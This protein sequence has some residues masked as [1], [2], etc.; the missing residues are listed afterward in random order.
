MNKTVIRILAL[1]LIVAMIV[2]MFFGCGAPADEPTTEPA[3]S[4]NMGANQEIPWTDP[5]GWGFKTANVVEWTFTPVG[6]SGGNVY[7]DAVKNIVESG[8]DIR[9]WD[10]GDGV[11]QTVYKPIMASQYLELINDLKARGY[12]VYSQGDLNKD[13]YYTLLTY[14]DFVYS[15]TYYGYNAEVYVTASAQRPLSPYLLQDNASTRSEAIE[16]L[17]TKLTMLQWQEG[18][19]DNYIIQLKSGHFIV[20]DGGSHHMLATMLDFMEDNVPEGQVPVV[21]AWFVTHGHYDHTGWSRAFYEG[22]TET[23]GLFRTGEASQRVRVNGVYLNQTNQQVIEHTIY[24][25]RSD[26]YRNKLENKWPYS[27]PKAVEYMLTEDG[28]KTPLYRPQAGQTLYFKDLTVE[29]PYTQEQ[30]TFDNY[31]MDINAASTWHLVRAEGRTFLDAGDTENVN[32]AYVKE[33]FSP[34]YD[35][36]GGN[37][38]IMSAFHHGHNIYS[39]LIDTYWAP[40][41]F[42]T[43]KEM[44]KWASEYTKANQEMIAKHEISYYCYGDGSYQYNFATGE[45]S[46]IG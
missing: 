12:Q 14:Q 21:D 38:D 4:A 5:E 45:V 46:K 36:F 34:E 29:I 39:D 16:G 31:Q 9:N 28:Q 37:V 33:T 35:A 26:G 27:V 22:Y 7:G 32:L 11:Y 30:I 24:G 15:V 43:S 19:G 17:D 1:L 13:V 44:F 2:P 10:V 6:A 23:N 3:Q 18:G 41:V 40:I 25:W 20:F 8:A 42:Y